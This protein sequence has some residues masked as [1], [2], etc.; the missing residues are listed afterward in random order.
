VLAS[1]NH[2]RVDFEPKAGQSPREVAITFS[3]DFFNLH[4][5]TPAQSMRPKLREFLQNLEQQSAEQNGNE[6]QVSRKGELR[7]T[8]T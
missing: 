1:E 8:K 3:W 2:Y 4:P 5:N 6:K 7:I